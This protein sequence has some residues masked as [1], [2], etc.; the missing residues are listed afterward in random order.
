MGMPIIGGKKKEALLTWR[1]LMAAT[2]ECSGPLLFS[3][4]SVSER[5]RMPPAQPQGR[6]DE[7]HEEVAASSSRSAGVR[8]VPLD[9]LPPLEEDLLPLS[10]K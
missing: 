7:L 10:M 2:W 8:P 3:V 4:F 6:R 9:A 5:R 1:L